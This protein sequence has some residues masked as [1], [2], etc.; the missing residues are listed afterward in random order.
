MRSMFTI[1]E[2]AEMLDMK[3]GQ[4]ENEL[5]GGHLGFTYQDGEKRITMY[6]LEKY[7]GEQQ[8]LTIVREY[9]SQKADQA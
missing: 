7:M 3:T 6:D 2:V 9:L 1:E 8:M 5:D 4:V